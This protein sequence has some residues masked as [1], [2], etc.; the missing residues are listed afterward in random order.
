M[1]LGLEV[2][3]SS[4]R[5]RKTTPANSTQH[6]KILFGGKG[7]SNTTTLGWLSCGERLALQPQYQPSSRVLNGETEDA[8]ASWT[9]FLTGKIIPR[10]VGDVKVVLVH[11]CCCLARAP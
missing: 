7:N 11:G 10:C 2:H 8:F 4:W 6:L 3:V 9:L 1:M 5:A